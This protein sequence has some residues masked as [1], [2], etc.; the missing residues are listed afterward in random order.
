MKL[1]IGR[2]QIG[3]SN[4][5][6]D[7]RHGVA[8]RDLENTGDHEKKS[9]SY[10]GK[11]ET[12]SRLKSKKG[13]GLVEYVLLLVLMGVLSIVAIKKLGDTVQNGLTKSNTKI[14][15]EFNNI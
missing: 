15:K 1:I 12:M 13:Q 11:G 7:S 9:K 4:E 3:D 5:R 2:L 6:N 14:A 10:D 8:E